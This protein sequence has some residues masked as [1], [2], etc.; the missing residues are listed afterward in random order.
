MTS[1]GAINSIPPTDFD[2]WIESNHSTNVPS[3]QELRVL[4]DSIPSVS[5][6]LVIAIFLPNQSCVVA[7][8]VYCLP[9]V[10]IAS[11]SLQIDRS[12]RANY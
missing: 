2:R 5:T 10:V 9:R 11:I 7:V 4:W 1:A 12:G 8:L 3:Q 6:W